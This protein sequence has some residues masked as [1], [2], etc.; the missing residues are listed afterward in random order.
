MPPET[1]PDLSRFLLFEFADFT[2]ESFLVLP[3]PEQSDSPPGALVTAKKWAKGA[4]RFG[5]AFFESPHGYTV[6]GSLYIGPDFGA[7]DVPYL[8]VFAKGTLGSRDTPATFEGEGTVDTPATFEG[9]ATVT[10]GK[11]KGAVYRLAGWVFP[12]PPGDG[13]RVGRI[14][15]SVCAVRGPDANPG[16]D[17]AGMELGTVGWFVITRV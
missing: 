6:S 5:Q 1:P 17:L 4:L 10:E 15:G 3:T 14:C 8:Y 2:Y 9:E 7:T 16:R 13:G 12:V 11:A